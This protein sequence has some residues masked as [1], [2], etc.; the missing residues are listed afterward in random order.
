M[1]N[2]IKNNRTWGVNEK[3][4]IE[5]RSLAN[6][7][8]VALIV[9]LMLMLVMLTMVP[10][11][12]Q[13]TSGEFD[14]T[15]TFQENREALAIA[16]AGLEHAKTMVQYNSAN[17]ILDGPDDDHATTADNG[18]LTD[19][20]TWPTIPGSTAPPAPSAPATSKVALVSLMAAT[21]PS[22][23]IDAGIAYVGMFLRLVR[24]CRVT[25]V[26]SAVVPMASI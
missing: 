4:G 17:D 11:A 12:L 24:A 8:G 22:R 1:N 25:W 15:E 9:A 21:G 16:E 14:R 5:C 3:K 26:P 6:E 18:T 2:H 10:A 13:L 20:G 7:S 23:V 19:G